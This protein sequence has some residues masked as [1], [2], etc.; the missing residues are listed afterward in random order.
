LFHL[1][2]LENIHPWICA[3]AGGMFVYVGLTDMVY[4]KIY[5]YIDFM[6]GSFFTLNRF[7][8]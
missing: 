8:N 3:L 6:E 2:E 5:F 7:Q 1:G 4:H